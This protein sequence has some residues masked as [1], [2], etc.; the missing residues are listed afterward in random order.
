MKPLRRAHAGS[1][2][3]WQPFLFHLRIFGYV[4][5]VLLAI[6]VIAGG[7]WWVQWAAGIWGAILGLHL[8]DTLVFGGG[9]FSFIGGDCATPKDEMAPAEPQARL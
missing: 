3:R 4:M 1:T 8:F 9:A 6:D 7:D 5:V 2:D